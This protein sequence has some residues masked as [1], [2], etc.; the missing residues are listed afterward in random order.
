[1]LHA[2]AETN[3]VTA[4]NWNNEGVQMKCSTIKLHS[5]LSAGAVG[6]EP[7][8]LHCLTQHLPSSLN[9]TINHR[10]LCEW[11]S[12]T[13]SWSLNFFLR[14]HKPILLLCDTR[15]LSQLRSKSNNKTGLILTWTVQKQWSC[16]TL[17][18]TKTEA[19]A[20]MTGLECPD[21]K[22]YTWRTGWLPPNAF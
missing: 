9:K 13:H 10:H 11:T 1:M 17:I 18:A 21:V 5:R 20:T 7:T 2:C 16:K 22:T 4:E 12:Y 19:K 6:F 8:S 14:F 3:D 15:H